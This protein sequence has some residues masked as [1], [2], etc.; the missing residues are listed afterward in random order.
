MEHDSRAVDE[1]ESGERVE[2]LGFQ[3]KDDELNK[4]FEEFKKLADRK[5]ELFDGDLEAIIMNAGTVP[6]GPWVMEELQDNDTVLGFS[7]NQVGEQ[8]AYEVLDCDDV[9][10]NGVQDAGDA[11]SPAVAFTISD[12]QAVVSNYVTD[13]ESE[14]FCV[15]LP[16]PG[17]LKPGIQPGW[18]ICP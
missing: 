18:P 9:D 16:G 5:K 6:P 1:G 17:S 4:A 14:P 11:L 8:S 12:G 3:L 7:Q 2:Q 15:T 13:G 10:G